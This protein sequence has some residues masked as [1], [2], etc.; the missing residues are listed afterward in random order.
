[1]N[2]QND[3]FLELEHLPKDILIVTLNS[4]LKQERGI[5][6]FD[7]LF[8]IGNFKLIDCLFLAQNKKSLCLIRTRLWLNC[9]HSMGYDCLTNTFILANKTFDWEDNLIIDH[10]QNVIDNYLYTSRVHDLIDCLREG[11]PIARSLLERLANRTT[12][13]YERDFLLGHQPVVHQI[14]FTN[15]V[16]KYLYRGTI[17]GAGPPI[18]YWDV[19]GV[20]NM[21]RLFDSITNIN[22]LDLTYWD[23][24]KII[25][26]EAM[27]NNDTGIIFTGLTNW[28]TC[29]VKKM[30]YM[31]AFNSRFNSDI[32]NWDVSK[33]TDMNC[34]FNN[35]I[36]FNQ[37]IRGWDTSRVQDMSAMFAGATAFNQDIGGWDTSRVTTMSAMFR[38][39]VSFNQDIGGWDT[40]N[41]RLM[42]RMFSRANTFNQ[43]IGRW[44]TSRVMDMFEMFEGA[45]SF[46]QALPW[47]LRSCRIRNNMFEGSNGLLI[48]LYHN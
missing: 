27:F 12:D 11:D 38:L 41:V 40:S 9:L 25:D 3:F 23:V 32:S 21:R 15:D 30:N 14:Q 2:A 44:N 28:N 1:M 13:P 42:S 19:R 26:M 18:K 35:A 36:N 45:V 37:D 8:N 29:R 43:Y 20:T 47:D 24:S 48:I 7:T 34:M 39:A 22:V 31:F 33:V 16:K 5:E 10:Q 4:L 6:I 17:R 46:N